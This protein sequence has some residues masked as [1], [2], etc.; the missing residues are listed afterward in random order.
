MSTHHICFCEEITKISI[1]LVEI[2]NF[3]VV[4]VSPVASTSFRVDTRVNARIDIRVDVSTGTNELTDI[5]T[6]K[7]SKLTRAIKSTLSGVMS[8]VSVG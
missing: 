4:Y 7:L 1:I 5:C 2:K 3:I 8:S 6:S